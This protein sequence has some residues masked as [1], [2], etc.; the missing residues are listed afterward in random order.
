M[1]WEEFA[2]RGS[3]ASGLGLVLRSAMS[4]DAEPD[5][6]GDRRGHSNLVAR[7]ARRRPLSWVVRHLRYWCS[8]GGD[9]GVSVGGDREFVGCGSAESGLGLVL[10]SADGY[11]AEPGAAGDRRG[12]SNLVAQCARRRPLSWVVRPLRYWCLVGGDS[13][14]SVDV[15]R[16]LR[17]P[18]SGLVWCSA[19]RSGKTPNQTLQGTGGV[20]PIWLLSA[21]AAGP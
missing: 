14:V 9:I 4:Y 7:C 21:P 8:V 18:A 19:G 2:G 1:V 15:G 20:T 16:K 17:G 5:A 11:D 3:A 6:A 12:H 10:R 13:W